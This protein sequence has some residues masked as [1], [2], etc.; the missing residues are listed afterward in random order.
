M[1]ERLRFADT[2]KQRRDIGARFHSYFPVNK[3][4]LLPYFPLVATPQ[5]FSISLAGLPERF[6]F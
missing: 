4:A 3:Q 2:T 5:R 1:D 6:W